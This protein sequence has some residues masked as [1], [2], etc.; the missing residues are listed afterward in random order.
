M[1]V[2]NSTIRDT[3]EQIR[4]NEIILPAF[5]REYVWKRR[6]I[7]NLFDSL[8]QDYP[9]NTM[10]FWQVSNIKEE[11]LEFYKFLNPRYQEG[12]SCNEEYERKIKEKKTIVIDGQQRLT[13]LYIGIYGSYKTEKLQNETYLYLDL[14][15][16]LSTDNPDEGTISTDRKYNFQFL[17]KEM[18]ESLNKRGGHWIRIGDVY[19]E[20]F[21]PVDYLIMNGP[22]DNKWA[23]KTLQRLYTLF[24]KPIIN[25][26]PVVKDRLQDV[27]DIFVR[28]NNGGRKLTKG[29]LLLSMITVNWAERTNEN[30]RDYVQGILNDNPYKRVDKDW[31]LSCILYVLN[32]EC[33]LSAE[34]FDKA[35]SKEIYDN[36]DT[37]KKAIIASL[38]LSRRFG[39]H[40]NGLT[41]KLA[42]L[43]IAHFIFRHPKI[44]DEIKHE[45][46]NGQKKSFDSGDYLLMRNWLFRSIAKKLFQANTNETLGKL[47]GIQKE[48]KNGFPYN[49]IVSELGLSVSGDDIEELL[50]T[51]KREAF[52]VLNI[53]YSDKKYLLDKLSQV[54]HVDHMYPKSRFDIKEGDDYDR[55]PNLQLLLGEQNESKNDTE[56]KQWLKGLVEAK[57]TGVYLIPE[58]DPDTVKF[59]DFYSQRKEQLRN[60]LKWKLGV[61]ESH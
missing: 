8:M 57:E 42:L 24:D 55:L 34:K 58:I 46:E 18:A 23:S 31:V 28:T 54:F 13:S 4:K 48:A 44:A 22:N 56:F 59:E 5:Q 12:V 20:D 30:A 6:D 51:E 14:D 61:S 60:I 25:Y 49:E 47:L 17:K 10:M 45:Y 39:L 11:C 43:P 35:T 52:P 16:P 33:K 32:K 27:L 3:L 15:G 41:T 29:D 50:R 36:K 38:E 53:I 37:I 1:Q 7:E 9:I 21:S 19:D 26:Y 2:N 40:E